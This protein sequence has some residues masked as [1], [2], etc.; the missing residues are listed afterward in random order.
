LCNRV[1]TIASIVED[2]KKIQEEII[3]EEN[4]LSF[5]KTSTKENFFIEAL[6]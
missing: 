3:L 4:N 5:K 6:E 1:S 2:I